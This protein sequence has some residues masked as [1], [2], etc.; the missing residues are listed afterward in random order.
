MLQGTINA[1]IFFVAFLFT[2][3]YLYLQNFMILIPLWGGAIILFS[4]T[5]LFFNIAS[6]VFNTALFYYAQYGKVPEGFTQEQLHSVMEVK[7]G[8]GPSSSNKQA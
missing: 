8:T 6:S 2:M 5:N 7:P 1:L 4:L 3:L